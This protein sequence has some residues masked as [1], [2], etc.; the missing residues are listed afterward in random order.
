MLDNSNASGAGLWVRNITDLNG[1]GFSIDINGGVVHGADAIV[2]R[3]LGTR[4]LNI[5]ASFIQGNSIIESTQGRGIYFENPV[6]GSLWIGKDALIVSVVGIETAYF[7]GEINNSGTIIGLNGQAI[8]FSLSEK[9]LNLV[10]DKG[11]ITGDI[12]GS[13]TAVDDRFTVLGVKISGNINNIEWISF[14]ENNG[15][16]SSVVE[17]TGDINVDGSLYI[18]D[19]QI[20]ENASLFIGSGIGY[21]WQ[22]QVSNSEQLIFAVKSDMHSGASPSSVISSGSGNSLHFIFRDDTGIG[23]WFPDSQDYT[24]LSETDAT[25]FDI[26]TIDNGNFYGDNGVTPL[27]N[28]SELFF[29]SEFLEGDFYFRTSET[30]AVNVTKKDPDTFGDELDDEN[31]L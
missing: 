5:G 29:D 12:S 7:D 9:P 14:G 20:H 25:S 4:V 8:D 2:F 28:P 16:S 22:G 23:L 1:R 13:V 11:E 27:N 10:L 30:L 15:R 21:E 26:M 18:P 31:K 19:V 6:K 3:A 17:V 24:A